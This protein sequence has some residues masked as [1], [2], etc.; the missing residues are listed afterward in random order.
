MSPEFIRWKQYGFRHISDANE[1][2]VA[3]PP[4][5]RWNMEHLM[6]TTLCGIRYAA[7]VDEGTDNAVTF[8]QRYNDFR[9]NVKDDKRPLCGHC[10]NKH[11]KQTGEEIQ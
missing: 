5:N 1:R 2:R 7:G 8:N 4:P 3:P 6:G 10:R 9:Y 11:K